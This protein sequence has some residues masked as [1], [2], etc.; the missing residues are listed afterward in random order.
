M[1]RLK[2][3]LRSSGYVGSMPT[4]PFHI[5]FGLRWFDANVSPF[6]NDVYTQSQSR[7][8]VD[9]RLSP[10]PLIRFPVCL[11]FLFTYHSTSPANGAQTGCCPIWPHGAGEL[12][13]IIIRLSRSGS[14]RDRPGNVS[15]QMPPSSSDGRARAC[16]HL[17]DLSDGP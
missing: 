16:A 9:D 13:L 1:S 3:F 8:S 2:P 10:I 12:N 5:S 17:G 14:R 11:T 15:S 4:F 6:I 7:P